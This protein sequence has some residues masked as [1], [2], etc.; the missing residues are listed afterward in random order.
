MLCFK[1]NIIAKLLK[2]NIVVRH[3]KGP[4]VLTT[5]LPYPHCG[6]NLTCKAFS[7]LIIHHLCV[8]MEKLAN[9]KFNLGTVL[10]FEMFQAFCDLLLGLDQLLLGLLSAGQLLHHVGILT[11]KPKYYY[12]QGEYRV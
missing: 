4:S 9:S 7:G 1:L 2:Y 10:L 6:M 5:K 11:Y 12:T 8:C 3:V